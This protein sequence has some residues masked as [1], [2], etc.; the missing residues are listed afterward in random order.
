MYPTGK[1]IKIEDDCSGNIVKP[2]EIHMVIP[3]P[4]GEKEGIISVWIDIEGVA[5]PIFWYE[6]ELM[7]NG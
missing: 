2:G 6:Y 4:P 7:D 1:K 3:P 5:F